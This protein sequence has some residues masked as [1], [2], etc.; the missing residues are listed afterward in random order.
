MTQYFRE[1]LKKRLENPE[2]KKQYDE[3]DVEFKII[4]AVIDA[5]K[6]MKLTQKELSER[7]GIDLGDIS[8][9]ER[10]IANPTIKVLM[11]LASGMG[12]DLQLNFVPKTK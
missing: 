11:K 1:D 7:S 3:L 8:R 9:I 12:M 4:R 6:A 5:R 2:F 10:G